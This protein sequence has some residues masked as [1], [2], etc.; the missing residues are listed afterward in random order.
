MITKTQFMKI[1]HE[2]FLTAIILLFINDVNAQSHAQKI[3]NDTIDRFVQKYMGEKKIPG[4]AIAILKDNTI[5]K[6]KGYGLASI[7]FN[8]PVTT[9]TK[10]LL[11][12]QTKLFTA[13]AIMKLQEQGKIKLDDPIN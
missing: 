2:F 9:E 10:F 5:V 7:E 13:I 11:D 3:T 4:C 6:L 12:S 1:L 8:A